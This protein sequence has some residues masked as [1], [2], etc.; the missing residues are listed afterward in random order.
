VRVVDA[1]S[2][3]IKLTSCCSKTAHRLKPTAT[4]QATPTANQA[5]VATAAPVFTATETAFAFV[6]SQVTQVQCGEGELNCDNA[7][8]KVTVTFAEQLVN[9]PVLAFIAEATTSFSGVPAFPTCTSD[10][11]QEACVTVG[12]PVKDTTPPGLDA[13]IPPGATCGNFFG[14]VCID[15]A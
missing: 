8:V 7:Q 1:F 15:P 11:D 6:Q 13:P 12:N 10:A 14:G 5:D 4:V 3:A 2:L 9:T